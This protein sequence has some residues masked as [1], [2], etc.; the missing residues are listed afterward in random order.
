MIRN[1]AREEGQVA[2]WDGRADQNHLQKELPTLNVET[3]K[4]SRM[5][6]L[7]GIQEAG[8]SQPSDA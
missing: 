3:L 4:T 6:L 8:G 7:P 5:I 1:L 2:G